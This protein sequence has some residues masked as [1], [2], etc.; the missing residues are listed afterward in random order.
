MKTVL[1][2]REW[3]RLP[4][5]GVDRIKA[6][7]DT[8][9]RTSALHASQIEPFE[10]D[11]RPWVRFRVHPLQRS[12]ASVV[13]CEAPVVDRRV[14]RSSVG[15]TQVRWVV[16]TE[17]EIAGRRRRIELT[18]TNRDAMGF[19]LLIGRTALRGA[20]LVDPGRSF[21]AQKGK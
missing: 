20:F 12:R 14:V 1:G 6:K 5:L 11:D 10:R 19:R 15:H 3:V 21:L 13:V 9:A 18:L 17:L 16:A 7:I 8:G 2:W 4:A